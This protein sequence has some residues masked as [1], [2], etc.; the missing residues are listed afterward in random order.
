MK[1][2]RLASTVLALLAVACGVATTRSADAP[3]GPR[4][5]PTYDAAARFDTV[6]VSGASFSADEKQVL[7]TMD[8]S[9]VFNAYRIPVSGGKPEVLTRSTTDSIFAVSYF[10]EDERVLYSSDKGGDELNHL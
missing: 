6:S 7:V 4:T 9:G 3:H 1:L 8:A 2:S 5:V 10:P